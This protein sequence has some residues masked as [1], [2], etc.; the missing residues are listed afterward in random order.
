MSKLIDLKGQRFGRLLV[1]ER[2]E[3]KNKNSSWL[4]RC[5]CGNYSTV[6]APNLK[7]G[8][9][10]SCG[11]GLVESTID[12]NTK[13]GGCKTKLYNVW[14]AMKARCYNK[15]NKQFDDYGGR[16]IQVCDEWLNN[17]S[18]FQKWALLNGYKEGLT[19]DRRDNNGN[20]CP[21]NCHWT[22][23]IEQNNNRRPRRWAKKPKAG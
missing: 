4:C 8:R 16:G 6:S 7:S 20:Y 17:Y 14:S 5:D 10:C 9:T 13:H 11:C 18:A 21:E 23:T 12:R 3:S 22:T 19:I 2:A 15:N 1:I